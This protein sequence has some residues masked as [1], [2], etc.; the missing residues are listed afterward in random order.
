MINVRE[1]SNTNNVGIENEHSLGQRTVAIFHKNQQ[2]AVG[3]IQSKNHATLATC[4]DCF[5]AVVNFYE[6]CFL[7]NR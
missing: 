6:G 4:F 3:T 2:I 1:V 5:Q 7:C